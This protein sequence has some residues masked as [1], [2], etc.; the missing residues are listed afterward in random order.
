VSFSTGYS[1]LTS[2]GEVTPPKEDDKKAVRLVSPTVNRV[3]SFCVFPAR[4]GT[5]AVFP[6][7]IRWKLSS[8]RVTLSTTG[9][10]PLLR[11]PFVYA[12]ITAVG[13]FLKHAS[14]RGPGSWIHPTATEKLLVKRFISKRKI[15]RCRSRKYDSSSEW[16]IFRVSNDE[17]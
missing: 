6:A 17:A 7:R 11:G 16:R 5:L 1:A 13:T 14:R 15:I 9:P 3:P 8:K 2:A 4:M 10:K 12:L